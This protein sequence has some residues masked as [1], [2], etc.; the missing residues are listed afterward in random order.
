MRKELGIF[1]L[2]MLLCAVVAIINPR[3]LVA[4]NLQ[5]ISRLIGM[6]GIL[7]IGAGV[8]IITSGIDLSVGSIM[9]LVGILLS[10]FLT[11]KKWPSGLAVL[12]VDCNRSR[13]G[14]DSWTVYHTAE[15]SAIHR[16][17]VRITVL[18]WAG[19]VYCQ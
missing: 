17:S 4:S 3:F 14:M 10:I 6:F 8:V 19:P 13:F 16:D 18:S 15:N 2:L 9:A 5:N 12:A 1:I 11:E 7:S